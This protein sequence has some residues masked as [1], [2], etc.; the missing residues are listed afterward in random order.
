[1]KECVKFAAIAA[2]IG[3]A[4]APAFGETYT[5]AGN[6]NPD[7]SALAGTGTVGWRNESGTVFQSH[8]PCAGNDYVIGDGKM[9]RTPNQNYAKSVF[10][11]GGDSLTIA[12]T[13]GQIQNK[14]PDGGE[15]VISN[16]VIKGD[17]LL[18][19]GQEFS[20][21]FSGA[22]EIRQGA[23]LKI[24]VDYAGRRALWFKTDFSGSGTLEIGGGGNSGSNSGV[25]LMNSLGGFAGRLV[26]CGGGAKAPC[27]VLDLPAQPG[28]PCAD[29]VKMNDGARL[30]ITGTM[31]RGANLGVTFI[32]SVTINVPAGTV[33]RLDGP[34]TGVSGFVKT[35]DGELI[36]GNASPNLSGMISVTAG[37]L[38]HVELQNATV[39]ASGTGKER[40]ITDEKILLA[41]ATGYTGY[42][43]D[44]SH[45]ITVAVRDP[46]GGAGCT[47]QWAVGKPEGWSDDEP[48]FSEA[49]ERT[50]FCK[51]SAD[52]YADCVVSATVKIVKRGVLATM[53]GITCLYDGQVHN[54]VVQVSDP[55]T[56]YQLE[57]SKDGKTFT[58]DPLNC[59]IGVFTAY[60][61][62]SK[63]HYT[64]LVLSCGVSVKF[65]G[66]MFVSPDG[67]SVAPYNTQENAATNLA[68][69]L[70][71]VSV[72]SGSTVIVASGNYT[73]DKRSDV[74]L[75]TTLVGPADRSARIF[76]SG[77]LDV[78][79]DSSVSGLTFDN[80]GAP[81][82]A[83]LTGS[84]I[85]NCSFV[86]SKVNSV[87]LGGTM[88]DCD[89]TD[90]VGNGGAERNYGLVAEGQGPVS[91]IRTR[92]RNG[93]IGSFVQFSAP[94]LVDVTGTSVLFED[95]EISGNTNKWSASAAGAMVCK[96]ENVRI[97]L[98]RCA[99][100][101]NTGR[102]GVIRGGAGGADRNTIYATNCLFAGNTSID[103]TGEGITTLKQLLWAKGEFVNCTFADNSG[104]EV[105]Y[106][107]TTSGDK[108]DQITL[109][110][111]IVSGNEKGT[112][113][114]GGVSPVFDHTLYPE[115][116]AEDA[117]GNI[118][119][120]AQFVGK[121]RAP[122]RLNAESPGA[123]AGA[124]LGWTAKDVDL[125]GRRRLRGGKVDM[126]C[127]ACAG[128]MMLLVQ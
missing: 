96:S 70:A 60:C 64:P 111:G 107:E 47:Y 90:F 121:G 104:S 4:I 85:T 52:G 32:G 59:V 87:N 92:I 50:V 88:V 8:K 12:E 81:N 61:R 128:G 110:N 42:E 57:W 37:T 28:E 76:G 97:V 93:T 106:C 31:S 11:F 86:N 25:T 19:Q 66:T 103:T 127:Y 18:F 73:L 71:L 7:T 43:D 41:S 120:P 29:T 82:V 94:V 27:S 67:R 115:C 77:G 95:C 24:N 5:L 72:G 35:G 117:N 101:G 98:N 123:G 49:G 79:E 114:S 63:A 46:E 109:R 80:V 99:F 112:I 34:L 119:G 54:P 58:S 105:F 3:G 78:K 116:A 83:S 126:G 75:R 26:V 15:T 51:I 68:E 102:A 62:I 10:V 53:T 74:P 21:G 48:R 22:W 13:G 23:K 44:D 100:T 9:A 16:L 39:V 65:S 124:L 108:S 14:M 38:S 69:A 2:M 33:V 113:R 6:D 122:Y 118:V 17:C 30:T 1:M 89:I 36:L 125:A 91:V 55:S 56:G 84:V 45:G 40:P 20:N